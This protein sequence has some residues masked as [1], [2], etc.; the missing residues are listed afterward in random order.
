MFVLT[1]G[2][3]YRK[4]IIGSNFHRP[5]SGKMNKI[6]LLFTRVEIT[7]ERVGTHVEIT[8]TDTGQGI[9]AEFLP[10]VFERLSPGRQL[11]HAEVWWSG[12]GA[13]DRAAPRRTSRWYRPGR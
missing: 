7:L 3:S 12:I 1:G 11:H 10:H 5:P 2:H 9:D 4:A 8:V 6:R 13:F